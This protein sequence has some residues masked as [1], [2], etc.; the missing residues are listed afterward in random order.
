MGKILSVVSRAGLARFIE[1]VARGLLRAGVS[2]NAVTVAGSIGVVI[3]SV[4]F[5]ARGHLLIAL[6]IVTVCALTDLLDGTMARLRGS[7][8]KW[9]GLL[10]STMDRISDSAILGS[11]VYWF[12][13][14]GQP[15]VAAAALLCLVAGHVIS[16]VRAR[17]E[18]LGFTANVG[19][20]ERAERLIIIG[21]GGLL[22]GLGLKV[23]LEIALW[24]LLILSLITI[25]QR[26]IHIYRQ[27]LT[28][29][30]EAS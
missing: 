30:Q 20:A 25:G 29:N 2:P 3:G 8:T 10:D 17:A 1:P 24:V 22:A 21:A 27:T 23:A 4:G 11:L 12:G 9:G 28:A 26:L 15:R 7:T 6:A 16:Y 13:T 19:F 14:S 18:S 5:A